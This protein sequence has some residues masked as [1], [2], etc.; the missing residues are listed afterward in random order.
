MPSILPEILIQRRMNRLWRLLSSD[1]SHKKDELVLSVDKRLFITKS[2]ANIST[3]LRYDEIE[4]VWSG[5]CSSLSQSKY[6]ILVV[7]IVMKA[8]NRLIARTCTHM[9]L[10]RVMAVAKHGLA[11][12][13]RIGLLLSVQIYHRHASGHLNS[14]D[15]PAASCVHVDQFFIE[16]KE[17]FDLRA[18]RQLLITIQIQ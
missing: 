5:C 9:S 1:S 18:L 15:F 11:F 8:P 14:H 2:L 16:T 7:V 12:S 4:T 10:A 6:L 17:K 13:G 3:I